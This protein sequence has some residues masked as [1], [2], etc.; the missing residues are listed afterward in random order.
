MRRHVVTLSIGFAAALCAAVATSCGGSVAPN[1][2]SASTSASTGTSTDALGASRAAGSAPD[3]AGPPA[4][5][6]MLGL[7]FAHGHSPFGSSS[8]L[9]TWHNGSIL[10]STAV[11]AIFWGTSWSDSTFVGDKTSGLDTFYGGLGGSHYASTCSEYTGDNGKVGTGVSYDGHQID[12]SA[13]PS[14]APKTSAILAEVCKTIAS[15]V[16]NGYYPVYVDTPRGHAAYC[17]WH[18]YGS[19]NGVPVQFAFFFDLD[20][21]AGC[22]PD[23]TSNLHS[24]GLA[25]L[26]NVSG[27]EYAEAITDPRNG[28]W[29]DSSGSENADKCVWT[30]GAPLLTLTNGSQWKIQ[31]NWSNAAFNAGTGYP[32]SAGQKGCLSGL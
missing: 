2:D 19:C 6:P 28:G 20:G 3:F 27:H 12:L 16:A 10:T 30:F 1:E 13:A 5:P 21:D 15:P 11:T 29:Y 24:Q 26:A 4:E 22:D 7:H 8:P 18:S 31:G 14:R 32:S 25:A 17:A 9:M 23:D